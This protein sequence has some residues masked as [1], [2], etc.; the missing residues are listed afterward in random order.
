MIAYILRRMLWMIPTFL[1]IL[2]INFGVLRL[3]G[4]TLSQQMSA[5]AGQGAETGERKAEQA[6][7]AVENYLGRFRRSGNDLPALVNLRGFLDKDDLVEWLRE[8][9]RT[10]HNRDEDSERNQREKELWL[11]GR[12]AVEPLAQ[13][14]AD[15]ALA[16]L[17]GPASMAL[18]L[19][20]YVPLNVEDL[21][22]FGP[23]REAHV[24]ER[25]SQ[26]KRLRIDHINAPE[27]GFRTTDPA[28]GQKRRYLLA[29]AARDTEFT[30]T[31]GDRWGS[32][33]WRTGFVDFLG[34][35]FTGNLYSETQKRYVFDLLGERWYITLW[36]NLASIAIAW[37]ISIPLG[38]RSA[39]RIGTLEDKVTTNSLFF[40]WSLPTF[41]I[42]TLLLHHLCTDTQ[43]GEK[44]FPNRGLSSP[45]SLWMSTP[46]YL[47]D[48]LWHAALP[49]AVLCYGSFTALSR[50]MRANVLEQLNSDYA[51]TARAKGCSEDQVVYRHVTRNS[52]VTMI[53][54]GSGLL[55]EL[56]G[57]FVIVEYIFSIPGLGSLLIDAARQQ[58]A[59]L[60]M[61]ST[62][63]SVALLLVGILVADVLYAVVDPRIRSR[64]G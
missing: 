29:L 48:L 32:I 57:G 52:M 15:D 8:T 18:S 39:R 44:L 60:V 13:V 61:G 31:A 50:Y 23:E 53:T 34:K 11:Q 25:N 42:G 21:E 56:F 27:T 64:Y 58:D 6:A 12:L 47:Y 36:L 9:Q 26:L 41:F 16:E 7:G 3:Q 17:H 51:R 49:L 4:L 24:R 14:L 55:A 43:N 63:I 22:R 37:G 54:L 1:G 40:L 33:L 45:G 28:A 10:P 19:C 2:V 30:R 46:A 38:I 59:P 5:Q 62:V 20:A 35:L